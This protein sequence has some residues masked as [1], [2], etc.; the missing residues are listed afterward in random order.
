MYALNIHYFNTKNLST[1]TNHISLQ[2]QQWKKIKKQQT[3]ENLLYF[4]VKL[5]ITFRGDGGTCYVV[6]NILQI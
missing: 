4:N 5:I 2:R 1:R 3:A 6:R